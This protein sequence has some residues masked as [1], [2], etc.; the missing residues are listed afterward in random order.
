MQI[1]VKLMGSLRSKLPPEAKGTALLDLEPGAVVAAALE[2]LG[3]SGG[4]VHLVMVNGSMEPDRQR[5]LTDGDELTVFP[6]VAG[7]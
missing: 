2:K 7:G 1:R 6:P 3:I 4:Q 5:P